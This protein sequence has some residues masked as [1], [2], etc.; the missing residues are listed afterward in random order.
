M[1]VYRLYIDESGTAAYGDGLDSVGNRYLALMGVICGK[2][3]NE[4]TLTP[5]INL[6]RRLFT[7]D[8]DNQPALHLTDIR[9]KKGKF[10]RLMDTDVQDVFNT[11]YFDLLES[12]EFVTCCVVLDKASHVRKY[13]ESAMHPYHY[14]L[15]VL[16]ERYVSF[17]DSCDGVG[18]VMAESRGKRED[19]ALQSE[20][21]HFYENGTNFV[22][23]ERVQRRLTSVN[24]KLK[25]KQAKVAGLELADLLAMPMKY[26]TLY[27]YGEIEEFS[28]NFSQR[29][30][31]KVYPK[32][33][34]HWYR[35]E[36]KG[37]GLKLI[38]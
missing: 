13:G 32:I 34:T 27:S 17:L 16:L 18:D 6:I 1:A 37:Y 38:K 10:S 36:V 24:L 9:C 2:E 12:T 7:D 4:Q 35:S 15:N 29:V 30:I 31:E 26:F 11:A 3:E 33:R 20:Y 28:E 5:K 22:K 14:C 8:I 25:P 23:S 21:K 19:S